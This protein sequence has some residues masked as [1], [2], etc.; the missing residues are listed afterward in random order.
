VDD[1]YSG[2]FFHEGATAQHWDRPE[3]EYRGVPYSIPFR[4][5]YSKN[6]NNLLMAGRNISASHLG[7]SNTRVM[8]TCAIM[9]HAAGTGAAFCVHE[10]TT[11]RG[12]YE[13]HLAALQQQLLKEGAAIFELQADDPRDLARKATVTASSWRTHIS[14]E[15]MLPDNIINGYARAVGERMKETTNAWGPDPKI[16][17]RYWVQLTWPRPV[18][19]NMIHIS[20]QTVEASPSYFSIEAKTEGKWRRIAEIDGNRHRRHVLGLTK[21]VTTDSIRFLEEEPAPVCEIRVYEEPQ[22][23]VEIAQRAHANMRTPDKGPW[24]P[25]GDDDRSTPGLD[26]KKLPGLVFDDPT[27]RRFG[28][29]V[30]S[31]WSDH[32]VGEGY[33]HDGNEDKGS[34]TLCFRPE[35]TKP[36]RFEIRLGYV[37]YSNRASRVAVTVRVGDESKIFHVNQR[38]KPPIDGL[39][40]PLGEFELAVEDEVRVEISNAN[41][42]GY[43]VADCV[44]LLRKPTSDN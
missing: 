14:G 31:T 12:V 5:L 24:L 39:F 21:R 26:P 22:R 38:V 4:C 43:V 32:Y 17:D 41:T 36:G 7:M 30:H 9:G 35:V 40:M 3:G 33:L 34:K 20:F 16:E 44:Q 18:T 28:G 19:L 2:G 29:W 10:E 23:L 37:A 27:S 42:D 25:W 11:P 1:H 13:H 8:L 6:V 15:R